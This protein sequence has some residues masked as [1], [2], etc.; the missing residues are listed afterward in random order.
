MNDA[1]VPE[2]ISMGA[3]TKAKLKTAL[4][5]WRLLAAARMAR[6]SLIGPWRLIHR[7][8][9][10]TPHKTVEDR[11]YWEA[12]GTG[13]LDE[14]RP[15]FTDEDD[16]H[17]QSQRELLDELRGFEWRSL[18]EV[19]CGFGWHL[20]AIREAFP[21]ATLA[22][23]DFS[24][25][26]LRRART[27]VGDAAR[28]FLGQADGASL[29][30]RDGSFDVVATSGFLIYIHPQEMPR[31]LSELRRITRRSMIVLEYAREDMDSPHRRELFDRAP[32]H[33][34]TYSELLRQ[35]GLRVVRH[36]RCRGFDAHPDRV[37]VS[38]FLAEKD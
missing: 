8:C 13:Y 20:R 5:T 36:A 2:G 27:Y 3:R 37:P 4:E 17:Y 28:V 32:W 34:H 18:L 1:D 9:G 24:A 11:T 21:S 7:V 6:R 38:Y 33:G 25:S 14:C 31:V 15:I 30:F 26:Q 22:G 35:A 29:P 19:G 12:R 10:H 23:V 16:P